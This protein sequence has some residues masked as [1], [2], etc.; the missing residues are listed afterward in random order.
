MDVILTNPPWVKSPRVRI[1]GWVRRISRL[2]LLRASSGASRRPVEAEIYH[3]Y[4]HY[5]LTYCH[6]ERAIAELSN[7]WAA[8]Q[9]VPLVDGQHGLA[10]L[11]TVSTQAHGWGHLAA[12]STDEQLQLLNWYLIQTLFVAAYNA[13]FEALAASVS[14]PI[15]GVIRIRDKI[16]ALNLP[17][18]LFPQSLRP[19]EFVAH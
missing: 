14:S 15:R 6:S 18:K 4:T 11:I 1:Q 17:K 16:K 2:S 12:L 5:L 9:P 3:D 7:A 13:V 19:I 8:S 10:A